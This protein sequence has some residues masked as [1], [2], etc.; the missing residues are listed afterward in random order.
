MQPAMTS[1]YAS[2]NTY[3][4]F[5]YIVAILYSQIPKMLNIL[6]KADDLYKEYKIDDLHTFL[7][8]HKGVFLLLMT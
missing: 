3:I 5:Y 4:F 2:K 1:H 7:L 6:E 8:D